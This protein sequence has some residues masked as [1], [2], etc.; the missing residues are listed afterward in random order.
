MRRSGRTFT[1]LD[2][3]GT[4]LAALLVAALLLTV[5]WVAPV[6]WKMFGD[7]GG[8]LS[9]YPVPTRIVLHPWL[10]CIFVIFPLALAVPAVVIKQRRVRRLL[11][12]GSCVLSAAT[13]MR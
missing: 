1:A 9:Q 5:F 7:M 4:V 3:A 13:P 8:D 10:M 12:G 2:W 6:F 11:L